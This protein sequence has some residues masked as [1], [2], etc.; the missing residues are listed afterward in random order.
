MDV[1]AVIQTSSNISISW[2][3][4][5]GGAN[6]Y[7]VLYSVDG[8]SNMTKLVDDGNRNSTV[9]TGISKGLYSISMFAYKDLP[10][11]QSNTVYVP[12]EGEI[13]QYNYM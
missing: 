1:V 9:L 11:L 5:V 10:S 8:G 2:S 3:P 6:G 4:P 7:V 13:T 12:F